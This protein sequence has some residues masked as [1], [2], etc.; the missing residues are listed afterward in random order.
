MVKLL[1]EQPNINGSEYGKKEGWTT[2]WTP[3][4]L[5][6]YNG[7]VDIVKQMLSYPTFKRLI[8]QES[9][10]YSTTPLIDAAH[11]NHYEV[12][13]ELLRVPG[14]DINNARQYEGL[15]A[16][17]KAVADGD[18]KLVG[19]LLRCNKTDITIK[20]NEWSKTSLQR[21]KYKKE[22]ATKEEEIKRYDD[23]IKL[24]ES[25]AAGQTLPGGAKC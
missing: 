20:K 13:L 15:T 2:Q 18:V 6:S 10:P 7:Y 11:N 25:R 17:D 19:I 22:E 12:V 23:I 8:N 5:A 9:V 24:F 16:L 21:A 1:L 4:L 3:L 14:I